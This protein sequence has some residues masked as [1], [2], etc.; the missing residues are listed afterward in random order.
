MAVRAGQ[1]FIVI[2][3]SFRGFKT[4]TE[5]WI[6]SNLRAVEVQVDPKVSKKPIVMPPVKH[7]KVKVDLDRSGFERSVARVESRLDR[8]SRGR[9]LINVGIALA[10]IAAP[11]LAAAVGGAVAGAGIGA[12][13]IAGVVGVAAVGAASLKRITKA[14]D[15]A[16]KSTAARTMA[17][18]T[19]RSAE[20]SLAGAQ[21]SAAGAR[22][23]AAR[24][25]QN[26]ERSVTDAQNRLKSSQD[27][28][29][30]SLAGLH[31]ARQQA[32]RDLQDL[33]EKTRDNDLSTEAASI[34]LIDAQ[35]ELARVQGSA[36]SSALD[37]R[38]AK[39]GVAE[40]EDR[41]S[42][43]RK[44]GADDAKALAKAEKGGTAGNPGVIAA[45]KAVKA[46]EADRSAAAAGVKQARQDLAD[47]RGDAARQIADADASVAAAAADASTARAAVTKAQ[48]AEAKAL[49]ALSPSQKA[50]AA[51]M[52]E[53]KRSWSGFLDII[54]P[55]LLPALVMGMV[56]L[57]KTLPALALFM[58]PVAKAAGLMFT[59][60]GDAAGTKGFRMFASD[61]GTFTAGIAG[62]ATTGILNLARGFGNLLTAF[63]PLSTSMSGGLVVLTKRF[64]DWSAGLE[65]SSGF[66]SFIGYVRENGPLLLHTLGE[67]GLAL[68]AIGKAAAPLGHDLLIVITH[69][70][71]FVAS[72]ADAHPTITSAIVGFV[73]LSSGVAAMAVPL[74]KMTSLVGGAG[75]GLL[76]LAGGSKKAFTFGKEFVGGLVD[77]RKAL[78]SGASWAT[79]FGSATRQG[80]TN[81]LMAARSTGTFI[82]QQGRLG[83]AYLRNIVTSALITTGIIAQRVATL[84]VS[85]AT[86]AW[87]A[88]QWLL[89]AAL[90]A[91]PIGLVIV[92]LVAFGALVVVMYKK[93]GW[94]R[95]GVDALWAGLKKG[96][97]WAKDHWPLLLIILTGPIGAAVVIITKNFS[98]IRSGIGKVVGAFSTAKDSI[99]SVWG[100]IASAVT[101]PLTT[102]KKALN[103]FF[104]GINSIAHNFGIKKLISFRFDLDTGRK[105]AK[106]GAKAGGAAGFAT[107]GVLPG[108][109]P[110][111]D[112]HTFVSPTAGKLR[113]SGGE[114]IMRPEWTAAVGGEKA[115]HAMNN[116]AI[117]GRG[118]AKGGV[119]W[120]TKSKH[121]TT[122]SGHDGIDLNGPGNGMGDPYFA[123]KSGTIAY[124]GWGRG[125]GNAVFLST[126]SG[127]TLTY[128]HS[129]KVNVHSGQRVRAGQVMGR[130][131]STGH[132]TGPH[133]HFGLVGEGPDRGAAALRFLGGAK[134]P[135]GGAG[136][137]GINPIGEIKSLITQTR[138]MVASIDNG[139]FGSLLKKAP[140]KIG[141]LAL[142][143]AGKKL[144]PIDD[145]ADLAGKVNP[146]DAG[147]L[148]R[149][150]GLMVKNTVRPE[151]VLSPRQTAV[152]EKAMAGGGMSGPI[153]INGDLTLNPDSTVTIEGVA[154]RVVDNNNYETARD[155]R[156]G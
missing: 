130:I 144:N 55:V 129:S 18:K 64:A 128:G 83:L 66:N 135:K 133:L 151:R 70:A 94:F 149:T 37:L 150:H 140:D 122:Y 88:G 68:I 60:F 36:T 155:L 27:A 104:D 49:G 63:M 28:V 12:A 20:Q 95:T 58:T 141:S 4:K 3:P 152:F 7:V 21:R 1:A 109:S 74:D 93:V 131:G 50:A 142:D 103:V 42:D 22:V 102:V 43:A 62:D 35:A 76:S 106:S 16:T 25:I 86:R 90:T 57:G 134:M 15:T 114:A 48:V 100:K 8:L 125:Y 2:G 127:P 146:F 110:G 39:L 111:R 54:D 32:V 136:G 75:N 107:G 72:F 89:N 123:A 46:A 17:V 80:A 117:G 6:K 38:R 115:V 96:F 14:Q 40:A 138:R 34:G 41:L 44:Q 79:T 84:A 137:S 45:Q 147:G 59:A 73:A 105:G 124:T 13:G 153:Q 33:R 19:L 113:L 99:K 31:A 116:A 53:L 23:S 148:A 87:A 118:F 156:F 10:P 69:V 24:Q 143:W 108:W 52:K 101:N 132:S 56:A 77:Q 51:G 98:K 47:A 81:T 82:V 67:L 120:P 145:I 92:G 11:A 85:A 119:V 154:Q 65:G 30:E 61:L 71:Q 139:P 9:F 91:N 112:I 29:R 78:Q 126:N 5:T 97:V 26:A 121:W